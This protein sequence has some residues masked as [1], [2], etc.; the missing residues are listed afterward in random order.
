MAQTETVNEGL[1]IQPDRSLA[2]IGS[3]FPPI[4]QGNT[5]P[6]VERQVRSFLNDVEVMFEAW[7]ARRR[8]PHTQ[9]SYRQGVMDFVR[10]IGLN[11][12]RESVHLFGI[13][14]ADV[15]AYRDQLVERGFAPATRNHRISALAG[16]YRYLREAAIE[17]RLPINVPNPAHSQFIARE[18]ADPVDETASLSLANAQQLR[19]LSTGEDLLAYRDRAI[20]DAYLYGGFRIAT[21][22]RLQ[23]S[24]FRWDDADPRLRINEKGDRRRTIGIHYNAAVSIRDYVERTGIRSG[25]L[26]RPRLNSRSRQLGNEAIAPT[27]MYYL[28]RSY[29]ERLSGSMREVVSSDGTVTLECRYSPHSLRATTATLLLE[30][31]EDIRKVQELL[32]HK[33]VTTTQ[34]YDKRRRATREGASHSVPI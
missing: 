18:S 6:E 14:V 7:I 3:S 29:L 32:G 27:T 4:L 22:C 19:A 20:I 21:G 10:F 12:P 16:F 30:S 5:T 26:F 24:D 17:L 34:I 9:R 8:S 33:H 1:M 23:V 2:E 13:K 31:H 11:W 28:L 15:Q 25:P